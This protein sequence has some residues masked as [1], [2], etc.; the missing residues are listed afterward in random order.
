MCPLALILQ[1]SHGRAALSAH[2]IGAQVSTSQL[3]LNGLL[4][5]TEPSTR[6]R[7][8]I[9]RARPPE[10]PPEDDGIPPG[11]GGQLGLTDLDTTGGTT[12]WFL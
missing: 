2:V 7:H 6:G 5:K 8:L 12:A 9:T 11:H 3:G 1:D 4:T 10:G